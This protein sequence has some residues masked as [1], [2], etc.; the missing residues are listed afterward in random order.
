MRNILQPG[1]WLLA[2]IV[3]CLTGMGINHFTKQEG[4]IFL[5]QGKTKKLSV[6]SSA[7]STI[8]AQ[9]EITLTLDSVI[10]HPH[11]PEFELLSWQDKAP[12]N[13]HDPNPVSEDTNEP[14]AR[15]PAEPM[16]IYRLGETDFYFRLKDFYPNFE[17]AYTYPE[18]RDTLT[19]KAPG[20]TLE[21]HT[22]DGRPIVTLGR[23]KPYKHQLDDLVNLG[24]TL[25]YF[26][27]TNTD[28]LRLSLL[29][30]QRHTVVFLGEQNE[31]WIVRGDSISEQP[32]TE[33]HFYST[34]ESDTIGFTVKFAFPDAAFLKAEPSTR[35]DAFDN[36]VARV[37]I[38]KEGQS[39]T[40][41]YLYP[42]SAGRKGG[43]FTV[44][45]TGYTLGL[46]T[47]KAVTLKH[48]ACS[49]TVQKDTADTGT[50]I[51]LK[52]NR[53]TSIYGY[54]LAVNDCLPKQR[55]VSMQVIRRKGG[56]WLYGGYAFIIIAGLLYISNRKRTQP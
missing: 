21:L 32:L 34:G 48:C 44:R 24:A 40:E 9:N 3:L 16:K 14:D 23:D 13:P 42:E 29:Q 30:L 19:P 17:F 36:P 47:L 18:K 50:R 46:G 2:G 8:S 26:W 6:G 4:T 31:M 10:L 20:I 7:D 33:G 55:V 27:N 22:P 15:Y 49:L 51:E 28:S 53:K 12:V 41:A 5:E 25:I 11:T 45:E 52:G 43:K 35:G 37:E 1:W 56:I 38:W 54:S 39:A